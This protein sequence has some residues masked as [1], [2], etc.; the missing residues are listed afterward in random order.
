MPRVAHFDESPLGLSWT[1]AEAMQR[2][3][4]ALVDGGRVWLV[5][6]VDAEGAIDRAAALGEIAGVIQL[7]DRHNRD[8]AA[9]AERFGVPLHK[10]PD[11]LPGTPFEVKTIVD[12]PKWSE[13]ML[14]WPERK[15]LVITEALMTVDDMQVGDIGVGPHLLLRLLP[16]KVAAEHADAQHLLVGHGRPLHADDAG[17]RAK[18]AVEGSRR[19]LPRFITRVPRILWGMR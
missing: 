19:D 10:L 9:L 5:D 16:P 11:D 2:S 15:A 1:L 17:V 7:L 3:S 12:A 13:K 14:W 18:Q 4:H 6:P 8:C